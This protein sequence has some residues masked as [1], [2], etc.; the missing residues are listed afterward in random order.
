MVTENASLVGKGLFFVTFQAMRP[1]TV[2]VLKPSSRLALLIGMAI[3]SKAKSP[4]DS[5]L[6]NA[7]NASCK[8]GE[9]CSLCTL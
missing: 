6:V 2:V 4:R 3:R 7:R 1:V 9:E 8:E 5:H